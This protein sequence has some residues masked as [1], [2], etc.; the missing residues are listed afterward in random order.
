MSEMQRAFTVFAS[1]SG[2]L[3]L[4]GICLF[5]LGQT[6]ARNG[7][8]VV[9]KHLMGWCLAALVFLFSFGLMFGKTAQGWIGIGGWEYVLEGTLD[10][11]FWIFW[12]SQAVLAGVACAVAS[13]G[14][15]ERGRFGG[16]LAFVVV[17]IGLI[18]PAV[19]HWVWGS[20]AGSLNMGGIQGWLEMRGFQDFAGGSV[21]H[22]VGGACALAAAVGAVAAL[23]LAWCVGTGSPDP[24]AAF[25]GVLGG[26][27]SIASG[28]DVVL[29]LGALIIGAGGGV[30]AFLGGKLLE[31]MRIDDPVNVA[32]AHLL[33]GL[34]G[35]L[36]L[37]MFHRDGF[38]SVPLADQAIGSLSLCL[39]AFSIAFAALKIIDWVL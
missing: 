6:R 17:F 4:A 19:G 14:L 8:S 13:Q 15:A 5:E 9:M 31:K 22:G 34:W 39:A 1:L 36:G 2:S 25:A 10:G 21:V 30:L 16:Y 27:A 33:G 28:A 24:S 7:I 12:F 23:V 18:Y 35:S 29:P 37:S 32:P 11:D 20:Q 3:A 26:L 38:G